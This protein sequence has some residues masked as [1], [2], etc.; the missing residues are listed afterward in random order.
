MAVH[1]HPRSRYD[2]DAV[3]GKCFLT[4]TGCGQAARRQTA[5]R[6][7]HDEAWDARAAGPG[8]GHGHGLPPEPA[9]CSASTPED[10]RI[11]RRA[12]QILAD[13]SKWNRRDTRVCPPA[14]KTWSLFCAL[15]KASLEVLGKYDHRRAALQEVRFVIDDTVLEK[16]RLGGHRLMGFNNLA[17][18]RFA[19]I[20][21]V[22][23]VATDA[24]A[25][26]L[27]GKK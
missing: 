24:V 3:R 15:Q 2:N 22:L 6:W 9:R 1:H 25:A 18:T 16:D 17:T 27:A 19:D 14:D 5:V 4:Y 10:L 7:R 8:A 26:K 12:D 20:K 21:R 11:L 13:E 23:K